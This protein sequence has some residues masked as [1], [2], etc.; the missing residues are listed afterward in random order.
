MTN[1]LIGELDCDDPDMRTLEG[2]AIYQLI[3]ETGKC[4][5]CNQQVLSSR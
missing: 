2:K 3:M 1:D 5:C 4:P